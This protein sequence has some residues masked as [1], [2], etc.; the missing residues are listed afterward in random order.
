MSELNQ[1][2]LIPRRIDLAQE[3]M[4]IRNCYPAKPE[5]HLVGTV[6]RVS[7]VS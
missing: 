2:D 6:D 1:L 7:I 5:C 3:R 4:S